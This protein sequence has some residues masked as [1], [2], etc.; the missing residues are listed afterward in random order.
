MKMTDNQ[1]RFFSLTCLLSAVLL[2]ALIGCR[3]EGN[4]P[5]TPRMTNP[6]SANTEVGKPMIVPKLGPRDVVVDVNGISLTKREV[7]ERLCRCAWMLNARPM[8]ARLRQSTYDRYGN[9]L[10]RDFVRDTL[11]GCAARDE[12][13]LTEEAL[14]GQVSSNLLAIA[15]SCGKKPGVFEREVPGGKDGVCRWLEEIAWARAYQRKHVEPV[16][17]SAE[18]VSNVYREIAAENAVIA[19]TN[20]IRRALIADIRRRI[21]AGQEDFGKLA[22]EYDENPL[23]QKDGSGYWGDYEFDEVK[24]EEARKVMFALEV[25]QVS[26]VFETEDCFNLVKLLDKKPPQIKD[27]EVVKESV[28]SFGR[29]SLDKE[30]PVILA[31]NVKVDMAR[32]KEREQLDGL[33]SNLTARATITYPHGTN[34]WSLA[35]GKSRKLS[36]AEARKRQKKAERVKRKIEKERQRRFER[37]KAA[38]TNGAEKVSTSR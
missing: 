30:Q 4:R 27:G 34:F 38:E 8:D 14:R 35:K 22:D 11:A 26:E 28:W 23:Q 31:G 20:E 12:K 19:R 32:Q 21:V 36:K 7:D 13:L 5:W 15:R 25:G 29:I 1:R 16:V 10:I 18:T 6:E 2:A 9:T 33:I 17:I 3:D 37:L 24:D